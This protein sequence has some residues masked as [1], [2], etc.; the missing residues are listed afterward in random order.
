MSRDLVGADLDSPLAVRAA[1]DIRHSVRSVLSSAK[2]DLT[3]AGTPA[4]SDAAA[5]MSEEAQLADVAAA[6]AA[7]DCALLV[8]LIRAASTDAV[9]K[10]G[11]NALAC[12]AKPCG[13]HPAPTAALASMARDVVEVLVSICSEAAA[14][15]VLCA[16]VRA[17]HTW[18]KQVPQAHALAGEAGALD[19]VVAAMR[20][21][22]AAECLQ[23]QGCSAL[24][25]L[26]H[27]TPANQEL[28]A[29]AG[30][31]V[32]LLTAMQTHAKCAAV[33][34]QAC[35]ALRLAV[36]CNSGGGSAAEANRN[37]AVAHRAI[38]RVATA[39]VWADPETFSMMCLALHGLV[40]LVP[41]S[42]ARAQQCGAFENILKVMRLHA[43][44][45]DVQTSGCA[46]LGLMGLRSST[47]AAAARL[48]AHAAIIHA[49]E[50]FPADSKLQ[51]YGC[52][53]LLRLLPAAPSAGGDAKFTG[54]VACVVNALR[55][56]TADAAVQQYACK[57]LVRLVEASQPLN[58]AE[59][60]RFG[61]FGALAEV[62]K[63][64]VAHADVV[65]PCL[66]AL[67]SICEAAA[68]LPHAGSCSPLEADVAIRAVA[69]AMRAYPE[70][71][72]MQRCGVA[73]S[74]LFVFSISTPLCNAAGAE[75]VLFDA[76]IAA[77]RKF[78]VDETLSTHAC[79]AIARISEYWST[80]RKQGVQVPAARITDAIAAMLTVLCT[81]PGTADVLRLA[82]YAL[83]R[84]FDCDDVN[85]S[86]SILSAPLCAALRTH[87]DVCMQSWVL[88][89]LFKVVLDASAAAEAVSAGP[90]GFG[91]VIELLLRSTP[92]QDS[93]VLNNACTVL[94][95]VACCPL[96]KLSSADAVGPLVHVLANCSQH[97]QEFAAFACTA[98][99]KVTRCSRQH[100]AEAVRRGA[101]AAVPAAA[102]AH[103]DA[104]ALVALLETEAQAQAQAQAQARAQAQA[105]AHAQA[106]AQAQAQAREEAAR[107]ADAFAAELIA[108]EEEAALAAAAPPARK[109]R[110]KRGGAAGGPRAEPASSESPAA[111]DLAAASAAAVSELALSDAAA[112]CA[113][114]TPSAA[115]ARR[116]RRAATKAARKRAAAS[117]AA[118]TSGGEAASGGEDDASETEAAE[119]EADAVAAPRPGEEASPPPEAPLPP[120]AAPTPTPAAPPPPPPAPT[121]TRECC[122]CLGDVPAADLLV[123]GPCG[124]RCLC[125]DCWESLGPP[126]ARRCP[127]CSAPA[128]MAMRVFE[129]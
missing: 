109:S 82:A 39:L 18:C 75:V 40:A 127:I 27:G 73:V 47:S 95:Q 91:A 49:M 36:T 25:V 10:A 66:A 31:V 4:Q 92:A 28:A 70:L 119:A 59:T 129:A 35:D 112:A 121:A 11:C 15:N 23:V 94:G 84:L 12:V 105:Q 57:C 65:E 55:A 53:G 8:Q 114:G 41:Q 96:A 13:G 61:A 97:N 33:W 80:W 118:G 67:R 38:L 78:V 1:R 34:L 45:S 50:R 104:A 108:E 79:V 93:N 9:R 88:H 124:H 111:P 86:R 64:H 116:H 128:A 3:S 20:A 89:A 19:A 26:L 81:H 5:A 43:Q 42:I 113:G 90:A 17:L 56:H 87:T 24:A 98:L 77:L 126:A 68:T 60:F 123:I 120:E 83:S 115:A 72:H 22:T 69:A 107:R 6:L 51:E 37:V 46:V 103:P 71:L 48:G 125:H 44:R 30:V 74:R 122:V 54:A 117:A 58:T 62:L 102:L 7:D 106:Q 110:K 100:A 76:V 85:G 99:L 63:T 14:E 32:T 101:A 29:E 21:K 2:R 16:G 52:L